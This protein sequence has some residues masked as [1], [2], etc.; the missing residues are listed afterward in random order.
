MHLLVE[1]TGEDKSF[2]IKKADKSFLLKKKNYDKEFLNL[3]GDCKEMMDIFEAE[4]IKVKF[5]DLPLHVAT[6]NENK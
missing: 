4:N 3:F 2:Y 5:K 1:S 6:Y